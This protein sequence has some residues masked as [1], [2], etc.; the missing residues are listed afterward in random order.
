M[1]RELRS[2]LAVLAKGKARATDNNR[3]AYN[4]ANYKVVKINQNLWLSESDY[5][6][7]WHYIDQPQ[8]KTRQAKT[9]KEV[10]QDTIKAKNK[11]TRELTNN[12]TKVFKKPKTSNL[13]VNFSYQLKAKVI[14]QSLAE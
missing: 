2:R 4:K 7:Q 1:S 9:S 8:R 10:L 14:T 12:T 6:S 5:S 11:V 3:L 13:F